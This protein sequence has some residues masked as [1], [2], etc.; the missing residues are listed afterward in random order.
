LKYTEYNSQ[1]K[2]ERRSKSQDARIKI[3]E[4]RSERREALCEERKA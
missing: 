1:D 3:K 4:K 2:Q